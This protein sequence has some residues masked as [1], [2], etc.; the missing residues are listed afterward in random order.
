MIAIRVALAL[1]TFIGEWDSVFVNRPSVVSPQGG[2]SR[3]RTT[4]QWILDGHFL[5]GTSEVN[6]HK[7]I[8]VLGYDANEEVY[9]CIR[10]TNAGQIDESIGTWDEDTHSFVLKVENE[11]PGIARTSTNHMVGKDTIRTHILAESEN[12]K[13]HRDLT[14]RSTRRK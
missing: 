12:G 6:N 3:G 14:I 4:A 9:R 5:L 13:I 2:T 11:R 1:C 10:M 7:S 8:W